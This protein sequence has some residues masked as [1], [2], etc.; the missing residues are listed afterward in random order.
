MPRLS[1][2]SSTR[3]RVSAVRVLALDTATALTTV[4][5]TDARGDVVA[6]A[7]LCKCPRCSSKERRFAKSKMREFPGL[8]LVHPKPAAHKGVF[9]FMPRAEQPVPRQPQLDVGL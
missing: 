5:V 6:E 4:A 8:A 9:G 1:A 3:P 2:S 7:S